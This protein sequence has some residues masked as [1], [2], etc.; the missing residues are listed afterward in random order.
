MEKK[1]RV[2]LSLSERMQLFMHKA[3]CDACRQYEKQSAL[4]E[5]LFQ[6]KEEII[7][8][9]KVDQQASALQEKI[10]RQLDKKD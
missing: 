7:P 5:R 6:S 9:Q 8:E 4:L 10:L 3:M 2:K 1:Q